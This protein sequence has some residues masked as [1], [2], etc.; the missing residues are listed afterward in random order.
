MVFVNTR[1]YLRR[2]PAVGDIVVVKHPFEARMII[3][4]VASTG[5]DGVT[6]RGDNPIAS[7]DSRTLGV[8]PSDSIIGE[9]TSRL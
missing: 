2:L 6:V 7:T 8:F 4:R 9:V 5:N 3:K 1:A